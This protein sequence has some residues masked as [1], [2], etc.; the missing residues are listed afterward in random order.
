MIIN[1]HTRHE[2]KSII[3]LITLCLFMF[4]PGISNLPVIDR[5]EARFAQASVQ[6]AETGNLM[7]IKFQDQSRYQKP[8]GIYWLQTVSIKLLSNKSER[9]IW[10]QRIPSIIGG[11]IAVLATYWSTTNLVNNKAG[12]IAASMLALSCLMVFESHVAKTDAILVGLSAL[13]FGAIISLRNYGRNLSCWIL[14][15]SLGLSIL[16]KGPIVIIIT[17][18]TLISLAIWEKENKWMKRIIKPIPIISFVLIWVPWAIFMW[19]NT[20]GEFY[21]ASLNNDF[22]AKLFKSQESHSGPIGYYFLSIWLTL[23]PTCLVILPTIGFAIKVVNDKKIFEE[24]ISQSVR[25]CI[26]AIMPY[27]FLI[28]IIPT[29]LM[30][31]ALP[32]FPAICSLSAIALTHP[33]M[34]TNF[35]KLRNANIIIFLLIS[36]TLTLLISAIQLNYIAKDTKHVFFIISIG[37]S[38]ICLLSFSAISMWKV[39]FNFGLISAC[40]ATILLSF[41]TYKATLPRLP[42][43]QVSEQIMAEFKKNEILLPRYGGPPVLS[44]HFKEPSL[45]YNL[46]QEINIS[47]DIDIEKINN[48]P[49]QQVFILDYKNN[50]SI[51]L[52][53]NII[54]KAKKDSF[55]TK[56]IPVIK[57]YNYSKGKSVD[58]RILYNSKC[59][60]NS[61][62]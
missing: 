36:F 6:M 46:G 1:L 19:L 23:W 20:D 54:A 29:K 17:S 18:L 50:S 12:F 58:I 47:G 44:P 26:A 5:D 39:K 59:N 14:W 48:T 62:N 22:G 41:V 35:L 7:D 52:E 60:K 53:K 15:L 9:K 45:V 31:Y 8:S 4:L 43:F 3:A 32:V 38:I 33:L 25:F 13:S 21:T 24:Q 56:S 51:K 2:L 27:W 10:V 57:G 61:L 30:H 11:I 55:C 28:E 40:I 42:M 16:I 34:K 37:F 49:K